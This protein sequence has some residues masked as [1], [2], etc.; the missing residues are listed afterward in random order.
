ME[1]EIF[2]AENMKTLSSIVF[3]LFLIPRTTP[4]LSSILELEEVLLETFKRTK[5]EILKLDTSFRMA[6]NKHNTSAFYKKFIDK[7]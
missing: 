5:C 4:A 3:F 2:G 6:D 1:D 7:P